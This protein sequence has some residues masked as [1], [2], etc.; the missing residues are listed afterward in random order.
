M[1]LGLKPKKAAILVQRGYD[2]ADDIHIL[3]GSLKASYDA[4]DLM[5]LQR[6]DFKM[7]E[8]SLCQD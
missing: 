1:G 5:T 6:K 3:R 8:A 7:K 4:L 2:F